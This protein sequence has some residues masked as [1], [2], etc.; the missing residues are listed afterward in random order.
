MNK[1]DLNLLCA[2]DVLLDTGSVSEA[3]ERM[4]LSAPAMSHTLARIREAL[5]DPILVR[6]GQRLIPTQRALELRE[7]VRRLVAEARQLMLP[8]EGP[9]LSAMRREFVVRAMDSFPVVFGAQLLAEVREA[10]P[11]AT[12]RFVPE[13]DGDVMALREGRVDVDI[14]TLHDRS[15]EIRTEL[16]VEQHVVGAVRAGHPLSRSRATLKRFA[17]SQHVA[18]LQRGPGRDV[19]DRVLADAGSVRQ[20][21]LTVPTAYGALM[22]ASQSDLVACAP[23]PMVR[24]VEASLGIVMFRLPV[25]VPVEQIVQGWHPRADADPAHRC[26]RECIRGLVTRRSLRQ[27][28]ASAPAL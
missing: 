28:G 7:P 22:A 4:Y 17:A 8:A 2:L 3:A 10:M 24:N 14:G 16:L 25:A 20:V 21:A 9:Q 18:V 1:L 11:L 27:P 23:E 15:P 6:A 5:G 13:L 26:L 19:L 12:V